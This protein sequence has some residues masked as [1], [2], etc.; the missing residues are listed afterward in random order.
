MIHEFQA[1]VKTWHNLGKGSLNYHG[2]IRYVGLYQIQRAYRRSSR[3]VNVI[4]FSSTFARP[5]IIRFGKPLNTSDW[6]FLEIDAAV[7]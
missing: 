3:C 2:G 4:A 6:F 5:K 1:V 7:Q